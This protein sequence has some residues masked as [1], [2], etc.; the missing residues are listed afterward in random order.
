MTITSYNPRTGQPNGTV[1]EMSPHD[2][3]AI[4]ER[5]SGASSAVAAASPRQ[6]CGWLHAVAAA[7]EANTAE[8]LEL[9]E[10]ETALGYTRLTSE[11]SRAAG[12]LR[13]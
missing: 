8:L 4:V 3:R 7:L 6:R 13:F 2:V 1:E 5:A 10:V 9:A 11:V 12:Q